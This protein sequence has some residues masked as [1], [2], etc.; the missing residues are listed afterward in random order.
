[1]RHEILMLTIDF[2]SG[3]DGIRRP[4]ASP[5]RLRAGTRTA[6]RRTPPTRGIIVPAMKPGV[7]NQLIPTV[8]NYAVASPF[9]SRLPL[10]RFAAVFAAIAL[11]GWG[12]MAFAGSAVRT[13]AVAA[14]TK[15]APAPAPLAPASDTITPLLAAFQTK[16]GVP[17]GIVVINLQ[18]G[19]TAGTNPDQVFTS[20]S[21]YKL[22]VAE[23]IYRGI[24]KGSIRAG[25]R[26]GNAGYNVANC[27]K[28]MI[29]ISDNACGAALGSM[30][31]WDRQNQRLHDAGY[32]NTWLRAQGTQQTS[33]ADVATF[34]KRLY[35]GTLLSPN[36]TKAFMEL[37]AAQKINNRL[38]SGLPT[39]ASIAHKT[40]DLDGYV[41]DAG[42]VTGPNG[43]YVIAVTTGPWRHPA[44]AA[45]HFGELSRQVYAAM[46][47]N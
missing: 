4:A 36:S 9:A 18:T 10:P 1:M 6:A 32:T 20:A 47:G 3:M 12:A 24:D 31:G 14:S 23:A 16:T 46:Q 11:A 43:S 45:A 13:P 2:M 19:A 7:A 37:L 25:D 17:A 26:A 8:P 28:Y 30:V 42:I 34:L 22:F 21:L 29:T 27:L 38:P 15:V 40:G 44:N 39:G 41:H 5:A 35:D 33:A